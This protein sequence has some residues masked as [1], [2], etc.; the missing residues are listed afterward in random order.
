MPVPPTPTLIP[1][2]AQSG[3]TIQIPSFGMWNNTSYAISFWNMLGDRTVAVQW[4]AIIL[5]VIAAVFFLL[6][7]IRNLTNRNETSE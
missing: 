3:S 6:P 5:L 1:L 2:A 7:L 4:A